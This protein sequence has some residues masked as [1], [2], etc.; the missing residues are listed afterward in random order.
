MGHQCRDST[1]HSTDQKNCRHQ[2]LQ[3]ADIDAMFRFCPDCDKIGPSLRTHPVATAITLLSYVRKRD[4]ALERIV[5]MHL[6]ARSL[7]A[8]DVTSGRPYVQEV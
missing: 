2:N 3:V 8:R 4:T 7:A 5:D 6:F 1:R